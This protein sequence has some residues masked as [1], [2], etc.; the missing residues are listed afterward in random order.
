MTGASFNRATAKARRCFC[1]PDRVAGCRSANSAKFKSVSNSSARSFNVGVSFLP[2][3]S[4]SVRLSPNNWLS[5]SCMI[6]QITPRR[7]LFFNGFSAKRI[8]PPSSF[9]SPDSNFPNV[10]FPAA[11]GPTIATISP[12]E[13]ENETSFNTSCK[14]NRLCSLSTLNKGFCS[15]SLPLLAGNGKFKS[16]ILRSPHSKT[17]AW[18]RI[19]ISCGVIT[20]TISPLFK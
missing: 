8:V 5:K 20:L 19:F 7:L 10:L 2:V 1:P 14:P 4:S 16:S 3:K 6:Y 9:R 13:Q 15:V 11:L 18:G 12:G 17:C